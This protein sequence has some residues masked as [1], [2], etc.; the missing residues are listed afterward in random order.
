MDITSFTSQTRSEFT[1]TDQEWEVAKAAAEFVVTAGVEEVIFSAQVEDYTDATGK[2]PYGD[3]EY[4]DPGYQKDG[5]KR[6]P[7]N[8]PEHIR[9]AHNYFSKPHNSGKYTPEQQAKIRARINS[10]WKKKIDPKGPP[11]DQK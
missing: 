6:Y 11:S 9:A 5:K 2:E 7:I 10:A 3:V 4:A 8:T 1:G